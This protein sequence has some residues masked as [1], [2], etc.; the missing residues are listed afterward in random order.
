MMAEVFRARD[1]SDLVDNRHARHVARDV[2]TRPAEF[3]PVVPKPEAMALTL[4]SSW[5]SKSSAC[6]VSPIR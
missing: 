2:R 4:N 5:G 1:A 6:R 3:Q